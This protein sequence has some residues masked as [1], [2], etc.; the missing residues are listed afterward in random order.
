MKGLL[1]AE[2]IKSGDQGSGLLDLMLGKVGGTHYLR[3]EKTQVAGLQRNPKKT[4]GKNLKGFEELR[5]SE[6]K[7]GNEQEDVG[8][9]WIVTS[10]PEGRKSQGCIEKS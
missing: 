9:S 1:T 2:G 5:A 6:R 3:C 10:G 8:M 4:E 7:S